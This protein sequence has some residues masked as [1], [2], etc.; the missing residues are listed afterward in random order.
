MDDILIVICMVCF[1]GILL[2][3]LFF[4][5]RVLNA[6]HVLVA[7]R[8]Q[9]DSSHLFNSEKLEKEVIAKYPAQKDAILKFV[10]GI[11]FS[12]SCVFW[13]VLCASACCAVLMFWS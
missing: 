4:R 1:A 7:N 11:R 12:I 8:V 10:G 13:L 6:Y 9:F 5:V 3:S 2:T